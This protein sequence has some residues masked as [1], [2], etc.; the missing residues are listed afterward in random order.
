LK[1]TKKNEEKPNIAEKRTFGVKQNLKQKSLLNLV[2]LFSLA[3]VLISL[4]SVIFPAFIA[5]SNSN[6]SE[7]RQLG[8]VTVDVDP[9]I[10]GVWAASLFV[11][12]IT[13][14]VIGILYFKKKLPSLIKT[15]I[16]YVFS[17]EVSKKVAFIFVLILL[18]F[19]I[20]MNAA[21]LTEIEEWEDY[22]GVIKRVENWSPEQI[23]SGFEPHFRHFMLWSSMKI[24]GYFTVI[25]FI[26]SILLLL[27]TYFFT[28]TITNKRFSGLIAMV[29]LIQS[30]VFFTYDTTVAYTN[31]WTLLYLLSL[32]LIYKVWPLSPVSYFLSIFSKALTAMFLPMSL[33]FIYRSEISRK[34]K[35]I[36]ASSSTAI[37]L[38]GAMASLFGTDFSGGAG[39][40]EEF[41]SNEFWLGFTSF[42][43]QLRFDGLVLVFILPLIFGLF[44]ATRNQIQHADSLMILIGGILFTAPLLTGFTEQTTQPYRFV[45]LIV[46]F[47]IGVGV[48]LSKKKIGITQ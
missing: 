17:Y 12:N 13:I 44:I 42:S 6:I 4:I 18:V 24:F 11:A 33:Y 38:V 34:K 22:P 8:I 48:L 40:Q 15:S 45:P 26:A 23:I 9:F 3:I 27:L 37:I 47:A 46:F 2:F 14:L 25:P 39:S 1:N 28:V 35:I 31:F 43:Y 36:I 29:I 21:E 10:T 30:N 5:S 20:V 41:D 19:F 16:E 7:L 32:F